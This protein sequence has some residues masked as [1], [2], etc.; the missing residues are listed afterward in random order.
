MNDNLNNLI[1]KSKILE[2]NLNDVKN[3]KEKL[4]NI[5]IN[6]ED[7]IESKKEELSKLE[8]EYFHYIMNN[9]VT[10]GTIYTL[11]SAAKKRTLTRGNNYR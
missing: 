8:E 1:I 6:N 9:P 2:N 4:T 10:N 7:I 3:Q 5:I 11:S